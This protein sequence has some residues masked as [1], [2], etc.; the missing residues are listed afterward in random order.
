MDKVEQRYKYE[1]EKDGEY[2]YI[3]R[4]RMGEILP[5]GKIVGKSPYIQVKHKY[6]GEIYEVVA[7]A[8]ISQ[9][10]RCGHCCQKYEN[11]FAYHVE[12]E[13]KL[14]LEDVWDFDK[15]T[16]NPYH[17]S[18][19]SN[20]KVW[21]KCQ[22]RD[23]HGSYEL[24]CNS[25][26]NGQRCSYCA[27]RKICKED[28]FAQYHINNTYLDFLDKY[29]DY[30]KNEV[31]PWEISPNSHKKIWIKCQEKEYHDSYEISCDKFTS[32]IRCSLCSKK[33]GKVHSLDSFGQWLV[34]NELFHL[35]SDKNSVDPFTI[36]KTYQKRKVWML[37]SEKDYHNDNGGYE[38]RSDHFI[39]GAR[40]GY[41]RPS[42]KEP[43]IH[44][45]DSFG[46]HN[47]DKVMSWHPDNDISPFRVP[48]YSNK[49]FKFICETCGHEWKSSLN[50]MT[51]SGNWCPN[52]SSSKG[53]KA[54]SDCLRYNNIEYEYEKTFEYLI[55]IRGGK[56]SYDFYL[57]DFNL[58]IEYQGEQ[59][60]RFVKGFHKTKKDFEIQLE[61][62]RRKREF[63]K[64]NGID[65]LEIW[66]YDYD[67]IE[68]ILNRE[69]NLN[70]KLED[71]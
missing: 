7:A 51:Y 1:V 14:K 57:P 24:A 4:Y 56:L 68:E 15:N 6:C 38:I 30:E 43:K 13:L 16:V 29:W 19:G 67:K 28:S 55:G 39:N 20:K 42:G 5:N 18:K 71:K 52:C 3:R 32:G 59:H 23:Y 64:D 54:I 47:F 50:N 33:S 60:E 22:E 58:L 27:S 17:I 9:E 2:E 69:L 12:K 35:W 11:S 37:C 31:S 25:F 36:S 70:N 44:M 10:Q 8:F 21:I 63:A 46:Y 53:E 41:C 26:Y 62:D 45:Y 40:C 65:L 61:H 34:D 66:H 49:K 48:K